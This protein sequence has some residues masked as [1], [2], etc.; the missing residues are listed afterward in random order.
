VLLHPQSPK[1]G[2]DFRETSVQIGY[3]PHH[4]T[5]ANVDQRHLTYR[6]PPAFPVVKVLVGVVSAALHQQTHHRPS[7]NMPSPGGQISGMVGTS[8]KPTTGLGVGSGGASR[9]SPKGYHALPRGQ[10]W[11]ARPI[12]R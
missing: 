6:R 12:V 11:H 10:A 7:K 9:R 4:L 1:P 8:V 2:N 5:P 3:R